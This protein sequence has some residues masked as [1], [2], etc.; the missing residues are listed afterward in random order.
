MVWGECAGALEDGGRG[1]GRWCVF[2]G[3]WPD[4]KRYKEMMY[5]LKTSIGVAGGAR[6]PVDVLWGQARIGCNR[7]LV[8]SLNDA[9]NSGQ[10]AHES[11][12]MTRKKGEKSQASRQGRRCC[13]I[14]VAAAFTAEF[15]GWKKRQ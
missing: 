1:E 12:L 3:C 13:A 11:K 4:T 5:S 2:R 9:P 6:L 8:H 14:M 10:R 7:P 15:C